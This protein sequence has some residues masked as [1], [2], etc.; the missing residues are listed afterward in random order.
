M[1]CNVHLNISGEGVSPL[2]QKVSDDCLMLVFTGPHQRGPASIILDIDVAPRQLVCSQDDVTAF[3]VTILSCQVEGGHSII[4]LQLNPC[5]SSDEV[6]DNI[7]KTLKMKILY[8]ILKP[9]K[10]FT[11]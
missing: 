1:Q 6:S 8:C 11:L 5:S 2:V 4:T 3:Q 10:I 7:G 9:F